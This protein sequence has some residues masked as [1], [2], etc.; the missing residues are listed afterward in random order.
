MYTKEEIHAERLDDFRVFLGHCW[1][2]LG[3]P[4]PTRV[5]NNI[6]YYLQNGPRR[7]IIQAF[8][9]VGK[10]WITAAFVC[11]LLFLNP[12][13]NIMVVSANK[14]R[15][16]EVT[17]F[18]RKL[19]DEMPMLQHLRPKP[20]ETD[21][22]TSFVVG[23]AATSKDPSVKSVGITGQLTGNRA[24][25]VVADDI[26]VPKNSRTHVMREVI[27]SL[28][29]EFDAVLKPGGR[30]IYLGTPQVEA[31]LYRRLKQRGYTTR[32]W[33][34]QIPKRTDVY[35]GDLA[36]FI[37]KAIENGAR[38]DDPVDPERFPR[39]E[40]DERLASYG[41]SEFAL[42]FM[43]DTTPSDAEK[44]PLKTKDLI[45]A[46]VDEEV[47]HAKLVWGS[48]QIMQDLHSGGFDGDYYVKPAWRSPEMVP[49]QG[50]VCA[51]DP[52]G[53]GS[54]ET[55]YAIVRYCNGLLYLID[56]GGFRDGFGEETLNAIAKAMIRHRVNYWVAEENYGGGMFAELLKP[57]IRRAAEAAK[58]DPTS[59]D[60]NAR[61]AA[62]D[63]EYDGWAS[64]Q[65]ELR[66]LDT[67]EP[68]LRGH[69]LVVSRP[70]IEKDAI[71]QGDSERFSFIQQM[72]RMARLKGCLANE[73]RL[74]A[75]SMA[76][77]YWTQRMARDQHE[78]LEQ[79]REELLALELERFQNAALHVM[80]N[81]PDFD[82]SDPTWR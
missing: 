56:V 31:S 78:A 75:V 50:T 37:L 28:V 16:E 43:L 81:V 58:L 26:E 45:I 66:I 62:F 73:D 1:A 17:K 49:F 77:G 10:S 54:D 76:C 42:Q 55:A 71:Q 3:L 27:S 79:H 14:E 33:P 68:I 74:E 5:Q 2:H 47:A 15:A 46:D 40:I 82:N 59:P 24:D 69:R 70:V 63:E 29:K 52:S 13:L 64:T 61:P 20:G 11:W 6:A 39:E 23:P 38:V 41:L 72:T 80:P 7:I 4:K 12:D 21:K 53:K 34:I 65:K 48:D 32:I 67:L 57:V 22:A 8:R 44:H 18:I 51:I 19:I 36:P 25:V 9:G 30:V 35:G 60:P